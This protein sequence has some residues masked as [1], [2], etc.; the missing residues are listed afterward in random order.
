MVALYWLAVMCMEAV[1]QAWGLCPWGL[2]KGG[3]ACRPDGFGKPRTGF[4]QCDA[5][6][7][8]LKIGLVLTLF[9]GLVISAPVSSVHAGAPFDFEYTF[10]ATDTPIDDAVSIVSIHELN[11]N[12]DMNP[13]DPMLAIAFLEL[14]ILGLTHESPGD[15]NIFLVRPFSTTGP[16]IEIMDDRGGQVPISFDG[17]NEALIFADGEGPLPPNEE[18]FPGRYA[19]ETGTFSLFYDGTDFGTDPWRV[20]VI[21]DSSGGAGSFDS[22]TLR[23]NYVP[24]PATLSL[25]MLG[26]LAMFHRRRR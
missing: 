2:P 9:A 18:I 22:I 12:F 7:G 1:V 25:L 6:V 19:P 15:I 23:G 4:F 16:G 21:D 20:I 10:A 24:E 11:F 17:T 5:E 13:D 26:A 3:T 8:K 14:E